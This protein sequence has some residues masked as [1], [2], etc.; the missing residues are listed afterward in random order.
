MLSD[1]EIIDLVKKHNM[2]SPFRAEQV[3]E[4]DGKKVISYGVSSYGYDMSLSGCFKVFTNLNSSVIDPK[5]FSDNSFAE[6][7]SDLKCI[8]PP[9]SFALAMSKEYF[10]MP[11]DIMAICL[12]KSTYARCGIIIN[13]TPLEPEWEG[14]LTIEISNSTPL[15]VIVYPHEGIA[16]LIF[17]KAETMCSVSYKDRGGKYQKQEGIVTAKL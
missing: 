6:I 2:I 13:V 5:N 15:P 9:N 11:R 3:R 7:Q 16:Q 8:I 4:V 14:Y 12:G 10:R 17:L 1:L